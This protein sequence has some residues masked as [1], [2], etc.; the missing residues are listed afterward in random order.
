LIFFTTFFVK[1]LAIFCRIDAT[2]LAKIAA[3]VA[4]AAVIAIETVGAASGM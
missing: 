3:V 4:N 2:G 1:G